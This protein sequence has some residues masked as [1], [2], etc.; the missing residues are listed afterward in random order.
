MKTNEEL[1]EMGKDEL[2]AMINDLQNSKDFWY[3]RSQEA[4]SRLGSLKVAL[5][6]ILNLEK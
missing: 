2:V 4:E 1:L 6:S 5:G 3:K